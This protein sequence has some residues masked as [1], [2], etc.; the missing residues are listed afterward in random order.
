MIIMKTT[1]QKT[2]T[3]MDNSIDEE[4]EAKFRNDAWKNSPETDKN[5]SIKKSTDLEVDR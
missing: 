1:K 5:V 3:K 4:K 2:E